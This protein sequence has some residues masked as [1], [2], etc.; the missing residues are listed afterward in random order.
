M[1]IKDLNKKCIEVAALLSQ[2]ET[3]LEKIKETFESEKSMQDSLKVYV[4]Y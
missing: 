3:S 4:V 1:E 2:T